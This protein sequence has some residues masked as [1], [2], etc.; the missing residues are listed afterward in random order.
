MVITSVDQVTPAWLTKTLRENE[1]LDQGEVITV[2]ET[3]IA[4]NT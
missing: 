2:G 1:C 3:I 4:A